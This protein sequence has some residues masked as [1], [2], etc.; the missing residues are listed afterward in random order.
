MTPFS[1][2]VGFPSLFAPIRV[3][4]KGSRKRTK[5]SKNKFKKVLN[6][7]PTPT[8]SVRL[9]STRELDFHLLEVILKCV[10]NKNPKRSIFC[11]KL[12]TIP[13]KG[14]FGTLSHPSFERRFFE[15]SQEARLEVGGVGGTP[16]PF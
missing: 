11:P 2:I 8:L 6:F 7:E 10:K 1:I 4:K 3:I 12:L 15:T 9:P 14:G 5:K 16:P 13:S